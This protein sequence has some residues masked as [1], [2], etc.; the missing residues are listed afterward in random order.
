VRALGLDP[1]HDTRRTFD[2]LLDAMSQPGTVQSVPSPADYAVISTLVDHEVTLATDDEALQEALS[3]QGRLDQASIGDADVVHVSDHM[4]WDVRTC[5]RGSPVE[6]SDGATVVYTLDT[7]VSGPHDD[8]ATVVLAGPGIDG[9]ARLS[10]SLPPAELSALREAQST[11]PRGV[12]AVFAGDGCLAA[13][14]RSATA[15][16]A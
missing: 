3:S 1:V 14:P 11:Y 6:P 13:L 8:C 7:V 12:D 16:V 10:V 9:T 15:E 4:D 2:G 5:N